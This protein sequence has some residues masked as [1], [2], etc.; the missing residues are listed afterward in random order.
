MID[1]KQGEDLYLSHLLGHEGY[2]DFGIGRS[3]PQEN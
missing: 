2:G 1:G 3:L